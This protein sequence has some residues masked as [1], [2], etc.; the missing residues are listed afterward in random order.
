MSRAAETASESNRAGTMLSNDRRSL[1]DSPKEGTEMDKKL[2]KKLKK[3][4]QYIKRSDQYRAGLDNYWSRYLGHFG[5]IVD[6]L[7][8]YKA[9]R[10]QNAQDQWEGLRI[11]VSLLIHS[12]FSCGPSEATG[13]LCLTSLLTGIVG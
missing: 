5:K 11:G 10:Q 4:P 7:E 1:V 3:I 13:A 6:K 8:K 9:D 12:L 2:Q